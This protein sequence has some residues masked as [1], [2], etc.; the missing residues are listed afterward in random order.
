MCGALPTYAVTLFHRF[1]RC[2]INNTIE[3]ELCTGFVIPLCSRCVSRSY[4]LH[5]AAIKY[6]QHMEYSTRVACWFHPTADLINSTLIHAA[7][8]LSTH[9][10][11]R[12]TLWCTQH[13]VRGGRAVVQTVL[14]GLTYLVCVNVFFSAPQ[15]I[16]HLRVQA[17]Y[18]MWYTRRALRHDRRFPKKPHERNETTR[19]QLEFTRRWRA[20]LNRRNR[21]T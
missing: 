9:R 16:W 17:W 12:A 13:G 19:G 10:I 5:D 15:A 6:A 2:L 14:D 8:E 4:R 21:K 11:V 20:S 3:S 18:M 7:S 1:A